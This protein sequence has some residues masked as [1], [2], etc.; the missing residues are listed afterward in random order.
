[1]RVVEWVDARVQVA[2]W[3]RRDETQ[4][5][6]GF[7]ARG[8]SASAVLIFDV[9]EQWSWQPSTATSTQADTSVGGGASCVQGS[10]SDKSCEMPADYVPTLEQVIGSD[11]DWFGTFEVDSLSAAHLNNILLHLDACPARMLSGADIERLR[12]EMQGVPASSMFAPTSSVGTAEVEDSR[13]HTPCAQDNMGPAQWKHHL[14]IAGGEEGTRSCLSVQ[15]IAD[16]IELHSGIE[17]S[18]QGV[19]FKLC[20]R[21]KL[22]SG[23]ARNEHANHAEGAYPCPGP[24][25]PTRNSHTY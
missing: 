15:T 23:A 5:A 7:G 20:Y 19:L 1:M 21:L 11:A 2:A 10:W 12:R 14:Q 13:G 6:S 3:E 9:P 18:P 24:A 4:W 22:P 17:R 16:H 8:H 25:L